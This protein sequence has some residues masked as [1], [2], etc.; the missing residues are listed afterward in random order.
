MFHLHIA[1]VCWVEMHK[2]ANREMLQA[3]KEG[4]VLKGNV[5]DM[6]EVLEKKNI[7]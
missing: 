7:I 3:L 1:G 6:M 5:D 4:G 2:L